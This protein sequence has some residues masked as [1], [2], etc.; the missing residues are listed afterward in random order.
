MMSASFISMLKRPWMRPSSGFVSL[1]WFNG[2]HRFGLLRNLGQHK[3]V[4]NRM[5]G[6]LDMSRRLYGLED[7]K[8]R[9]LA[10]RLHLPW[11]SFI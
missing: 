10:A 6:M 3:Y 1:G 7:G 4:S 2:V 5:D 11:V 9:L 8:A